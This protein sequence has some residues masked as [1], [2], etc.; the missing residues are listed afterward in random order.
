MAVN[1]LH[2]GHRKDG[3]GRRRFSPALAQRRARVIPAIVHDQPRCGAG[4]MVVSTMMRQ[5]QTN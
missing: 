4:L 5:K 2:A 3:H 1:K